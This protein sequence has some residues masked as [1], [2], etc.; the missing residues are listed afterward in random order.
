[1]DLFSELQT[2]VYND[3]T[4]TSDSTLFPLATVK[5]AIN[6]AYRK[7]GGLFRWA[8][9]EDAQVTNTQANQQ[10]YDYP[11]K[12]RPDSAWKLT[13]DG[14]DYGDPLVFKDFLYELE[15]D[16]PS[17]ADYLWST[18]WRRYFIYPTPTTLG[19]SNISVWGYTTVDT[20]TNDTDTTIFSY[21]L[22]ECNEAVV[23][24]AIAILRSK[25]E[26]DNGAMFKS[27]EAK[28]ILAVAWD[29]LRKEQAKFEKTTPF[30]EVPDL[31]GPINNKTNI[32]KFTF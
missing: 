27:A 7:A 21:S 18:Q 1:M 13:V 12:W 15:N 28:Q 29:R 30:L 4:T 2:A 10:Y 3:L 16:I 23:L 20:L 31:F 32:G 11:Q 24:E 19:S 9:L 5:L 6:R 26:N 8:E 25:G 14:E 17:G 22:P